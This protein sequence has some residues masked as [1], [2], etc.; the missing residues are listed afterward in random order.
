[1]TVHA[2]KGLEF[3]SIHLVSVDGKYFEEPDAPDDYLPPVALDSTLKRHEFES[4]VEKHNLLYVAVSRAKDALSIYQNGAEYK[5]KPIMA[6]EAAVRAGK[7]MATAP[8]YVLEQS[9]TSVRTIATNS[10]DTVSYEELLAYDRCPRQYQYRFEMEMGQ[11]LS[12]NPALQA[13]GLVR[14]TLKMLAVSGRYDKLNEIFAENWE[15]SRLPDE[16][17]DPQLWGQAWAAAA[18]GAMYLSNIKGTFVEPVVNLPGISL[19]LPWGVV[20]PAS[21]GYQLHCIDFYSVSSI[22]LKRQEKFL[23]QL[24]SKMGMNLRIVEA[25]LY[26][27]NRETVRRILPEAVYQKSLLSTKSAGLLA[28]EFTP[29]KD[30]YVCARCAYSYICP[31]LPTA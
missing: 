31:S 13:R 8:A 30:S 5:F 27:I 19:G 12:P 2:S 15:G 3:E 22:A 11:E 6:L 25:Y 20:T 29:A 17:A 9:T 4:A 26:D 10:R 7:L 23:A 16:G 1:M 18:R 21:A 14:Q 28:G 24:M